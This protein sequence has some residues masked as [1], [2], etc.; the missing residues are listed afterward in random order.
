MKLWRKSNGN[1]EKL[2]IFG[3]YVSFNWILEF[4]F[5]P[6]N[7]WIDNTHCICGHSIMWRRSAAVIS[8]CNDSPAIV[9]GSGFAA[10]PYS[11]LLLRCEENIEI[12]RSAPFN[13]TYDLCRVKERGDQLFGL[14]MYLDHKRVRFHFR[15][16]LLI[17]NTFLC[18][19][20]YLGY[21]MRL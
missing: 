7:H 18:T 11:S 3:G 6:I 17:M 4:L 19:N 9:L 5:F 15:R 14:H 1:G 10:A 16:M 2:E 21:E 8:A 12:N 13:Y 20:D